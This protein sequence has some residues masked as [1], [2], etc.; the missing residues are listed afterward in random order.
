MDAKYRRALED[1]LFPTVLLCRLGFC[2]V[3]DSV[4]EFCLGG[5]RRCSLVSLSRLGLGR[6]VSSSNDCAYQ[7]C[8]FL[9]ED[10][11]FKPSGRVS[12]SCTRWASRI[13]SSSERDRKSVV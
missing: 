11:S 1:T 8:T 13:G 2:V 5:W 12:S 10:N 6:V 4:F 9:I 7:S 3:R